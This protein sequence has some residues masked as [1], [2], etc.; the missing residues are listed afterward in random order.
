[1]SQRMDFEYFI[2]NF[3]FTKF[4]FTQF[5]TEREAQ[6]DKLFYRPSDYS[7]LV[8][9]FDSSQS[10]LVLGN[11]GSGKTAIL[12]DIKSKEDVNTLSA[13]M[14]DFSTLSLKFEANEF[15]HLMINKFVEQLFIKLV[16]EKHRIKRLSKEQKVLLVYLLRDFTTPILK[17]D[18]VKKIEQVS[19]G[20][21]GF[22]LKRS[23]N[24]SRDF[25][26]YGLSTAVQLTS[27]II[28]QHFAS[29]PPLPKEFVLNKYF[30]EAPYSAEHQF[31][32]QLINYDFLDRCLQ[33]IKVLGFTKILLFMDKVDED[34]RFKNDAAEIAEF[35]TPVLTDNK[36]LLNENLQ[37]IVSMWNIPFSFLIDQVRS[38]KHFTQKIEWEKSDLIGVL[39]KRLCYYS[40]DRICDYK[41][42]FHADV[43]TEV[44]DTIFYLS[45]KNPRDLWHILDKVFVEQFKID[46]ASSVLSKTAVENGLRTFVEQFNYY[47]YYPKKL[48]SRSDSLDI[49][50]YTQHLLRVEQT[51]FTS[52][53]FKEA[54]GVSGGSVNNYI[55][56][57][58]RIGL[59]S[60]ENREGTQRVYQV[61]DPKVIHAIKHRL[62]I[63]KRSV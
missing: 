46:P 47:E 9:A 10:I 44:I 49:Y 30:P 45:N 34:N 33:L 6:R 20:S 7:R 42:L 21:V 59:I 23:Y 12:Y 25:L 51:Q 41:N 40:D 4:P 32:K 60:E 1:M 35:I 36:L 61:A 53:K 2:T 29:L 50:S 22:F 27:D 26:N 43:S 55:A 3:K 19:S 13:W 17:S 11:R 56:G 31:E 16:D 8:E 5:S 24:F 14:D 28:R 57:M 39:N 48:N 58:L 54:T 18:L 37:L 62:N 15:Y 63:R 38:Q 52:T